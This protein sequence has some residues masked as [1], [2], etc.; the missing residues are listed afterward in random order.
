[1]SNTNPIHWRQVTAST[2]VFSTFAKLFLSYETGRFKPDPDAFQQVIDEF[3]AAPAD[4]VFYDDTS[5]NV[6]AARKL[7]IDAH[8]VSGLDELIRHLDCQ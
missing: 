2:P 6:V 1:M 4:I 7:G 3:G 8:C 5:R